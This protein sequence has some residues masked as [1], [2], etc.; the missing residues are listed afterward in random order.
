MN[1]L[2]EYMYNFFI[3]LASLFGI[4]L[5]ILILRN[6]MPDDK[7]EHTFNMFV[8]V[9]FGVYWLHMISLLARYMRN[10]TDANGIIAYS[11]YTTFAVVCTFTMWYFM[12]DCGI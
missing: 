3:N 2:R 12:L 10:D 6:N 1:S 11:R 4:M 5:L 8:L 9:L 7:H